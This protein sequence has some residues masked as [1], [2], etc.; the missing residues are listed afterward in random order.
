L[1]DAEPL[2]SRDPE[3]GLDVPEAP[4][5]ADRRLR[6]L[7]GLVRLLDTAFEIPGTKWRFGLD[8]IIGLIPGVGDL[9]TTTLSVWILRE[10]RI[11]G[12]SQATLVRMGWNVVVDFV[13]GAVPLAGDIFDVAWKANRKNLALLER[14][15]YQ[16]RLRPQEP[17]SRRG[18]VEVLPPINRAGGWPHPDAAEGT[19]VKPKIAAAAVI[20]IVAAIASFMSGAFWGIIL[21]VIAVV[22]GTLGMLIAVSPRRR[23]GILSL[24]SIGLGVIA[25][26]RAVFVAIF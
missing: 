3:A 23:G 13:V 14:D 5:D 12:V 22:A 6:R 20:A 1:L 9:V 21:A 16:R 18:E 19:R 24:A 8:G 26:V 4:A 2:P 10:A 17:L 11:L 15:L 7:Q 25:L